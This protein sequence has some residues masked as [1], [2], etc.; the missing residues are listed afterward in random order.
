M[1]CPLIVPIKV[2]LGVTIAK[3]PLLSLHARRGERGVARTGDTPAAPARA[4]AASAW[5]MFRECRKRYARNTKTMLWRKNMQFQIVQHGKM[6]RITRHQR[7]PMFDGC[8]GHK[9]I[10]RSDSIRQTL[11]FDV[12]QGTMTDLFRQRQNHKTEIAE[13]MFDDALLSFVSRTLQQFHLGLKRKAAVGYL[14]YCGG[15][16]DIAALHPNNHIRIK[17]HDTVLR[18][19]H[20]SFRRRSASHG[21]T[22]RRARG[23][24]PVLPDCS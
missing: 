9:R 14:F 23:L 6:F 5:R 20:P 2:G 16:L 22:C 24:R 7:H 12:N 19:V 8:R 13:K 18:A 3:P 21:V 11:R 4:K 17:E 10:A 1:N 15:R